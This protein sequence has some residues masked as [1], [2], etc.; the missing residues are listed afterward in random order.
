MEDNNQA[1]KQPET[2]AKQP[3]APAQAP[4]PTGQPVPPSQQVHGDGKS[5]NKTVVMIIVAIVV[6]VGL[7][8]LTVVLL[9]G[10]SDDSANSGS[11]GGDETSETTDTDASDQEGLDAAD[12]SSS[13][14][15]S[16]SS[17]SSGDGATLDVG[18]LTSKT[19]GDATFLVP[20]NWVRSDEDGVILYSPEITGTEDIAFVFVASEDLGEQGEGLLSLVAD[21]DGEDEFV[22][23]FIEGFTESFTAEATTPEVTVV[24]FNKDRAILDVE[25]TAA[26]G[27]FVTEE[28]VMTMRVV[29]ED[30]GKLAAI[31]VGYLDGVDVSNLDIDRIIGSIELN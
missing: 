12:D 29:F 13:S 23:G 1:P 14:N 27:S 28:V 22:E 9:G 31:G 21:S 5:Q 2:P 20:D 10:S 4:A 16:S 18:T 30:S 26:A 11:E 6:V 17:S 7:I 25:I 3:A 8:I 24:E 19:E 15:D